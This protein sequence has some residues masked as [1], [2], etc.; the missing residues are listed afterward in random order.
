MQKKGHEGR[1]ARVL[2]DPLGS[3]QGEWWLPRE[4]ADNQ[5]NIIGA[6]TE[7]ATLSPAF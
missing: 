1:S 4:S 3:S 2:L 6:A 5:G 7:T